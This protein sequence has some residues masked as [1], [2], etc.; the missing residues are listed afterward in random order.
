MA[1]GFRPC[2][3]KFIAFNKNKKM[4]LGLLDV[5]TNLF[6][7]RAEVTKRIRRRPLED[8]LYVTRS[9]T[10]ELK[11][12]D[13]RGKPIVVKRGTYK[14]Q[15]SQEVLAFWEFATIMPNLLGTLNLKAQK[16]EM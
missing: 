14:E 1:I 7:F 10:G 8:R 6:K 11:I 9:H 4:L 13:E 2:H 3:I 5:G 16:E 15:Y 12:L